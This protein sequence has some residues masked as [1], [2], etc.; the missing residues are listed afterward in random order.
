MTDRTPLRGVEKKAAYYLRIIQS[1]QPE[2]PY[3]LGGYSYGGTLAYEITRQLQTL[4]ESVDSIVMLDSSLDSESAS[5][6]KPSV[7]KKKQ[8][9]LQ[10]VNLAL[11]E[12]NIARSEKMADV[13]IHRKELNVDMA[14]DLFLKKLLEHPK[15]GELNRTEEQAADQIRSIA[16]EIKFSGT[17][18]YVPQPL[19]RPDAVTCYYF[20]NGSGVFWGDLEPYFLIENGGHRE[21]LNYWKVWGEHITH[22]HLIDVDSANH[23]EMLSAPRSFEK[24]LKVCRELY[25]K[26]EITEE[27]LKSL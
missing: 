1:V 24:I 4:G 14:D 23:M 6:S 5:E 3:H 20:R 12:T 15:T 9:M 10:A 19:P 8:A 21:Q 16:D 2:G 22:F 13:L 17:E 11:F 7:F 18:K 25:S 26:N 27:F